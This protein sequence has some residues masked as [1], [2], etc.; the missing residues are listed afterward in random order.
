MILLGEFKPW[1]FM[2]IREFCGL[3]EKKVLNLQLNF[4]NLKTSIFNETVLYFWVVWFHLLALIFIYF[5][6]LYYIIYIYIYMSIFTP[7]L[8]DS[9]IHA[10]AWRQFKFVFIPT[11]RGLV[12]FQN[13]F[14]CSFLFYLFFKL[15]LTIIVDDQK[16]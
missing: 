15:N 14:L 6:C 11:E 3:N 4:T 12:W 10:V 5:C 16:M 1:F 13:L 9:G 7:L 8:F 2:T